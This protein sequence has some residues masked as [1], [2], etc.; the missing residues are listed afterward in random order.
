M[1]LINRKQ[2]QT[3]EALINNVETINPV[4][5]KELLQSFILTNVISS[6]AIDKACIRF[7]LKGFEQEIKDSYFT[8]RN[9]E[10]YSLTIKAFKA[11]NPD[12]REKEIC[13]GLLI[14]CYEKF[15]VNGNRKAKTMDDFAQALVDKKNKIEDKEHLERILKAMVAI[16][17]INR[18]FNH[19]SYMNGYNYTLELSDYGCKVLSKT[20]PRKYLMKLPEQFRNEVKEKVSDIKPASNP[21][22]TV[23]L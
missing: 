17:Y 11:M 4:N 10:R 21:Y 18:H 6:R 13:N 5:L 1:S 8:T 16:G 14:D 22:K 2:S 19:G 15:I 20:L 23:E 9:G 3:Q 12:S 7:D